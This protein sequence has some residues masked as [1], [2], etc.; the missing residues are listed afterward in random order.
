M[1]PRAAALAL[2]ATA[3]SVGAHAQEPTSAIQ[4][5]E[6][7]VQGQG[8]QPGV[9]PPFAGGQVTQ[10]AGLGL[11]G[12]TT[13]LKS[14]FNV[15]GYTADLI[16]GLQ[17]PTVA[18]ALILDSSVRSS[19]PAGGIVDSFNI[20][21]LPVGEGNSGEIAFDG[22]YGVAPNFRVFTD[23]AE[24]IEVLKGPSA[25]LFGMAPNGGV[26]GTINIVPKRAEAD[27]TRVGVEFSSNSVFGTS[28]D[29][30]RRYGANR[31]FGVR[32]NGTLRGG[33][34]VVDKQSDRTGI[35]SL[36][37]DYQGERFRA[38]LYLLAQRDNVDAPSRPFLMAAGVP[39]PR[40]P[41]GRR[42]V[43][44]PW[45]SSQI[46]ERSA[47][48]RTE[49]D[50]TDQ[51]TLFANVG[52]SQSEVERFFGLPT[53]T[54]LSGDTTHTPQYFNLD[55]DRQT[56]NAGFRARFE[57]G[58]IRHQVSFVA[59]HYHDELS[60]AL[61][62]GTAV[63][64]NIYNPVLRA[65]QFAPRT[66]KTILSESD[67]SSLAL[68]DTLSMFNER[69]LLT[70][71]VRRQT[72]E[73]RNYAPGTG[74]LTSSYDESATTPLVGLV[75]RPLDNVSLY[76]NYIEGLS[77]G[78][79]APANALNAGEM[80]AP[81]RAQQYEVGVKAQFGSFGVGLA[82]F[83]ITKPSGELSNGFFSV[84]GEQR[85]RGLEF[86][87]YGEVTPEIRLLGGATVL[88]GELTKT[89]TAANIG[90]TPIGVPSL[91]LNLGAEW[92]VPWLRGLTLS[93]A[94]IHT[95]K[96]FVNTANTQSLPDWT[97]LDVGA[98]YTTEIAGRKTVLR[99]NVQNITNEKY[100]S[101]VASFGTFYVG[102][103][104]TFRL[105]MTVDL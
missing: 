93:G 44:Q 68:S 81:Y 28:L 26:G 43:I 13:T 69:V 22:V 18:E 76:A 34:T 8:S 77:R 55:V 15:T 56:Y 102:T 38:W 45:E 82:G 71:G 17:A 40:A 41:D 89:T 88:D 85:I 80:F 24:R 27:L 103:P 21:G 79:V 3:L 66:A 92:D 53:I 72:V 7:V 97:R 16:K 30:A 101:S 59:S 14:P 61:T 64:S 6:I 87:V 39:V 75:L 23:Y 83:Q 42:N 51:I 12:T 5:G 105:S 104:R 29:F 50:L 11:L 9:S 74:I 35:G 100:W 31:E 48:F 96:Q 86:N 91:Q 49:Y 1:T 33:D 70:L 58:F 95:G 99:A 65:P 78:D 37:L 57:T 60:R 4:L 25:A 46:D 94:L 32:V 2:G 63:S 73:A 98:R 62:S 47:L 90:N 20:R 52:G 84:S 54:N 10:G 36:A 19:H 67:L